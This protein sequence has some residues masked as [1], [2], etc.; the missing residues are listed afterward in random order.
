MKNVLTA[1]NAENAEINLQENQML[2]IKRPGF[3]V[4]LILYV[5][6]RFQRAL[7]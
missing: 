3:L 5:P 2:K 6:M 1:E 7:R 4:S